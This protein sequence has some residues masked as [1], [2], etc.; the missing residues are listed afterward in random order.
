[1]VLVLVV[2]VVTVRRDE[3]Q[4]TTGPVRAARA[5][6]SSVRTGAADS[7]LHGAHAWLWGGEGGGGT[8][9]SQQ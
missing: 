4:E 7:C 9:G 5:V 8:E 6:R 1:V 3:K 2:V